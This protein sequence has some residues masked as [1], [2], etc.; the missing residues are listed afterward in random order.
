MMKDIDL[1]SETLQI[2]QDNDPHIASGRSSEDDSDAEKD[3]SSDDWDH[4]LQEASVE[5]V[6]LVDASVQK[7]SKGPVFRG[8]TR[9]PRIG[10]DYEHSGGR[11]RIITFDEQGKFSGEYKSEFVSFMGDR[12]RYNV[13]LRFLSWKSVPK[14]TKDAIWVEITVKSSII[15]C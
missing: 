4:D 7:R 13:G 9:L 1:A 3:E 8:L 11:K 6:S 15:T 5:D 2:N 10:R 12:I 14:E